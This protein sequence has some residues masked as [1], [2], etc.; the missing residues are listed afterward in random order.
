MKATDPRSPIRHR[1]FG[2]ANP[3]TRGLQTKVR[4][5]DDMAGFM[6]GGKPSVLRENPLWVDWCHRSFLREG[7]AVTLAACSDNMRNL[8]IVALST[9]L[10]AIVILWPAGRPV[11]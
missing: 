9:A 3:R 6:H 5:D 4:G 7:R 8:G 11:L 2:P 10:P 1:S